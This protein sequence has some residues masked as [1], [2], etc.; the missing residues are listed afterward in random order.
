MRKRERKG[1]EEKEREEK[2]KRLRG[3]PLQH[4]WCVRVGDTALLKG[5]NRHVVKA[6]LNQ[7]LERGHTH[8]FRHIHPKVSL[9][10]TA[11]ETESHS[12]LISFSPSRSMF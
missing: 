10:N 4:T 3:L 2:K 9:V 8:R 12:I 6:I 11:L 7:A 1:E 5:A